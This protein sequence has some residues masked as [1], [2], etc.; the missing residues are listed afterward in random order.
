MQKIESYFEYILIVVVFIVY[1]NSLWNDYALDDAIVITE[2]NFVKQG[3]D[4]IDNIFT[5]ESFTGFFGIDKQLVAGGRYRPLS[6]ATFAIEREF[7]GKNPFISHFINILLYAFVILLI[8]QLFKKSGLVSLQISFFIALLYALHPIHT[9]AVANIKGRD[10]LM[11]FLFALTGFYIYLYANWKRILKLIIVPLSFFLAMLSKEHAVAFVVLMP[12]LIYYLGKKQS[13]IVESGILVLIPAVAFF[14]LRFQVLGGLHFEESTSLM[15]NPF[16]GTSYTERIATVLFTWLWYLKLLFIPY[17]LT[18]DY[19]P[20]HVEILNF[21]SILPWLAIVLIFVAL[22]FAF[23]SL[24][25]RNWH[26]YFI[27]FFIGTF[28]LMSNLYFSVGTFMNE[29]FM[30]MPSLAFVVGLVFAI[31]WISK[32]YVKNKAFLV[33]LFLLISIVYSAKTIDRNR[34]WKN[35]FTLFTHDVDISIGSAKG[36]CVA[37]GQWYE[38]ALDEKAQKTKKEYLLKARKYLK[39]SLQIYPAYNDAHLLMG[40][41][42]Y[43]LKEPFDSVMQH[44]YSILSRAPKHDNAWKNAFLVVKSGKPKERIE[45][46]KKLLQFDKT[47]VDI[48]HN[49]GVTYGRDLKLYEPSE[50]YLAKAIDIDKDNLE[51]LKDLAVVYGMTQRFQESAEALQKVVKLAPNDARAWYNLGVSLN[52]INQVDDAQNAFDKSYELDPSKKHV[53]IQR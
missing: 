47:N 35:D 42:K 40:N 15:N 23:K 52:A 21:S 26:G 39:R 20:Y 38:K 8:F 36:N 1:G 7:F 9:E 48:L 31:R 18:Y 12:L 41:V 3:L 13:D 10:E 34:D 5:T 14:I 24:I 30:F 29:R 32:K 28:F 25:K 19:Y 37:G 49:L 6:I 53:V 22:F 2:N 43:N 44:Y 46:Y 17:P 45:W 27:W 50:K 11:A 51:V 16:I 33:V 4:G